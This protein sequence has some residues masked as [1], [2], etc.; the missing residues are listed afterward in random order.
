MFKLIIKPLLVWTAPLS[1]SLL[2]FLA[3]PSF[4]EPL[5]YGALSVY[6]PV[7]SEFLALFR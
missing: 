4:G 2:L 5:F 3:A 1:V 7:S 6:L